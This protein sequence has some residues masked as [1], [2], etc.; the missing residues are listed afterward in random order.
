M[1]SG[2]PTFVIG[3]IHGELPKLLGLLQTAELIDGDGRWAG[4]DAVLW[5]TGDF[6]DRGPDGIGAVELIM[7][8]QPE[9]AAAGGYVGALLGNHEPLFLAVHR[10]ERHAPQPGL[11]F[12]DIWERNGGR[13]TDL[14][15][16]TPEHVDWLTRLPAMARVDDWLLLHADSLMYLKYGRTLDEVNRTLSAV[17]QSGDSGAWDRLLY[18]FSE[19]LAFLDRSGSAA[20]GQID[21][22][23]ERFG[24]RHIVHGHTPICLLTGQSAPEVVAPLT[25]AGGRCVNIDG[26]MCLGGPGFIFELPRLPSDEPP[27]PKRRAGWRLW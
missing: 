10:F 23:L 15:R 1:A 14:Q 18:R 27:G 21:R 12:R 25:Y 3:D 9:A 17:L 13:L 19:R 16:L 4:R 6:F 22:V 24:G 8:L 11:H 2:R 20:S 7:R 5:F 26:G